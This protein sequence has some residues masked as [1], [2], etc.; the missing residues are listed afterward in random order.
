MWA[1]F[2]SVNFIFGYD[3]ADS[4]PDIYDHVLCVLCVTESEL[5][6][7]H[8]ST[9]FAGSNFLFGLSMLIS[10]VTREFIE[11]RNSPAVQNA[12]APSPV[13]G[14]LSCTFAIYRSV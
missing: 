8:K 13:I 12:R 5:K 3:F 11:T 9:A 7:G 2:V 6:S 1:V 10:C 14:I 4:D